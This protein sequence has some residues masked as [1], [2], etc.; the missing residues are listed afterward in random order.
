MKFII[1][2]QPVA[3]ARPRMTRSGH[4]YTPATTKDYEE[5]VKTVFMAGKFTMIEQHKPI[6]MSI[7]FYFAI[8][9]SFT[10]GKLLAARH[11]VFRPT[12]KPDIDNLCKSVMDAINGLAYHDDSQIVEVVASKWYS[13]DPRVEV[14]LKE[15][16][17]D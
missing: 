8:P 5:L 13:T 11:N 12:V 3:K 14:E 6:R 9:K 17:Y 16:V 10:K 4:V 15:L 7:V 2:G 1:P